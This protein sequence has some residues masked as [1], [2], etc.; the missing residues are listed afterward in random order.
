M[1][2]L[3]MVL[4]LIII[5]GLLTYMRA[6]TSQAGERRGVA[7][8][9]SS[10]AQPTLDTDFVVRHWQEIQAMMGTGGAG[11]RNALIEADKLLDYVMQAK[12][13]GGGDMGGRLKLNGHKF[14][15]LNGVW[16]AHKLRNRYAHEVA[17]DV[18]PAQVHDAVRQ[19]GQGIRDLGVNL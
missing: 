15:D 9:A 4:A 2:F 13:F 3:S 14:S 10:S 17:I 6:S 7:Q 12:G 8:P 1:S 16:S 18:V 11:L 19:L 5:G